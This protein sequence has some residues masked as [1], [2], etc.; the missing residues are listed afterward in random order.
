MKN[1][2]VILYFFL[3]RLPI[4]FDKI[5]MASMPTPPTMEAS[6]TPNNKIIFFPL[7]YKTSKINIVLSLYNL[8]IQIV[9]TYL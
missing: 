2:M 8:L 5:E 1:Q 7:R 9:N 6:K 3:Y 4:F